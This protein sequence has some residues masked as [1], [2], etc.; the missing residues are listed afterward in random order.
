MK[1]IRCTFKSNGS[2]ITKTAILN[3]DFTKLSK[4]KK[5]QATEII[6]DLIEYEGVWGLSFDDDPNYELQFKVDDDKGRTLE[7]VKAITWEGGT[8]GV[9]TD[10]QSFTVKR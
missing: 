1:T 2:K 4:S 9:I 5:N 3:D 8:D 6:E 10:V 7:P